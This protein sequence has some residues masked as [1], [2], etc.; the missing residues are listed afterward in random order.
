MSVDS[1]PVFAT[2]LLLW[3]FAGGVVMYLAT[4]MLKGAGHL[5]KAIDR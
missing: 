1:P 3:W 5:T 2:V 4:W